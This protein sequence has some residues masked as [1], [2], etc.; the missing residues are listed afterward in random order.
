MSVS[1]VEV[2]RRR[3]I[4]SPISL[5]FSHFSSL[6]LFQTPP[7]PLHLSSKLLFGV[8]SLLWIAQLFI[9]AWVCVC[10]CV[11]ACVCVLNEVRCWAKLTPAFFDSLIV[12]VFFALGHRPHRVMNFSVLLPYLPTMVCI[13]HHAMHFL[14]FY[15]ILSNIITLVHLSTAIPVCLHDLMSSGR[16]RM[17]AW[18]RY[19]TPQSNSVKTQNW[20]SDGFLLFNVQNMSSPENDSLGECLWTSLLHICLDIKQ[21]WDW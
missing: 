3:W 14:R 2:E 13:W 20:T 10:E 4:F 11:C 1:L 15:T 12:R 16:P 19:T 18:K 8:L 21:T 7:P 5:L 6:L 9:C 17:K